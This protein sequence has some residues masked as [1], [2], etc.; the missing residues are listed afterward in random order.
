MT[1]AK[2]GVVKGMVR[3]FPQ[4]SPLVTVV[5]RHHCTGPLIWHTSPNFWYFGVSLK[6]GS[7]A[8][9]MFQKNEGYI[10]LQTALDL[11]LNFDVITR[12]DIFKKISAT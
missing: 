5:G 6:T 2:M 10:H 8:T 12:K 11:K 1:P 9:T 4:H 7:N 3:I